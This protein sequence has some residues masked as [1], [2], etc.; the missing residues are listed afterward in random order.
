MERSSLSLKR[1]LLVKQ[2]KSSASARS[3]AFGFPELRRIKKAYAVVMT[4]RG[5]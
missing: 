2:D 5:F 4:S 1:S 3:K